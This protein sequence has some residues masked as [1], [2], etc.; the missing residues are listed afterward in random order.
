MAK[1]VAPHCCAIWIAARPT[2][3][4]AAWMSTRSPGPTLRPVE[5]RAGSSVPRRVWSPRLPRS[6]RSAPATGTAA[7][8]LTRVANPPGMKPKTRW[9][10]SNPVTPAPTSVTMPDEVTAA[11]P[12]RIAR[13]QAEHVE[14]V[15]EVEACGLHPDLHLAR[16]RRGHVR[17]DQMKVVDRAAF[18]RLQD[19]IGRAGY[20][21]VA[22]ARPRQQPRHQVLSLSQREFGLVARA[23]RAG[24]PAS[25]RR[26]R[27]CR[28]RPAGNAG[29]AAR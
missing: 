4:L 2:P 3:P 26:H 25:A 5:R 27:I 15:P 9:P 17:L 19:V 16:A 28:S 13:I 8:T 12:P 11:D 21:E 18:G 24:R 1:T 20:R 29:P 22:A 10:T 14:H 7:G 6:P 23:C